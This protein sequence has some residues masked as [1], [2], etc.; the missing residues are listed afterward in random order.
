MLFT[1]ALSIFL[2]VTGFLFYKNVLIS[3][4][5]WSNANKIQVFLKT[6]AEEKEISKFQNDISTFEYVKSVNKIDRQA[7]G[8]QFK[9]TLKE[10]SSGVITEDELIDLIPVTLEVELV[11]NLSA[12]ERQKQIENTVAQINKHSTLVEE[13]SYSNTWLTKFEKV[14]KYLRFMGAIAFVSVLLLTSFLVSLMTRV[15]IDDAK[16]DIEVYN[17]IGATK[18]KIYKVFFSDLLKFLLFGVMA[19]YLGSFVFFNAVKSQIEKTELLPL[20]VSN[21]AFLSTKESLVL[22]SLVLLVFLSHAFYTIS[23][24]INALNQIQND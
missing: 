2:I 9:S 7:A 4:G 17:L 10:F 19:S 24:S 15:Y 16:N 1:T 5:A 23:S 8:E 13:T 12:Q 22:F 3:L 14:D 20:F 21:F 11:S 18:W 6:D